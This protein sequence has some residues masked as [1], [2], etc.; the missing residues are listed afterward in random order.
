MG[1][2]YRVKG[3]LEVMNIEKMSHDIHRE[4]LF[5]IT[6]ASSLSSLMKEKPN[7]E[8]PSTVNLCSTFHLKAVRQ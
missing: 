5:Q 4:F 3:Q 8:F 2:P 7:R 1:R 6:T